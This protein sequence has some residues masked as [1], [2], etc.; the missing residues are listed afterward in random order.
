MGTAEHGVERRRLAPDISDGG[1][2]VLAYCVKCKSQKAIRDP[3]TITTKNARTARQGACP[4]CG[5]RVTRMGAPRPDAS[6]TPPGGSATRRD[7]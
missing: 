7:R 5:V 2:R 1:G 4:D 6:R 3:V